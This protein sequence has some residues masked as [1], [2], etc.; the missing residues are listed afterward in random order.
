MHNFLIIL[1]KGVDFI[2]EFATEKD[3]QKL[4]R[5]IDKTLLSMQF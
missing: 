2:N 3:L 5:L 1:G 4:R